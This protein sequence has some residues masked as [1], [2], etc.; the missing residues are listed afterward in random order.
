[1]TDVDTRRPATPANPGD[2]AMV[3]LL[4]LAAAADRYLAAGDDPTTVATCRTQLEV[5]L[6]QT[7]DTIGAGQHA[8]R[9]PVGARKV[10]P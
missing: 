9:R 7:W 4:Q 1:M 2:R 8:G 3:L 10:K 5:V 6:G